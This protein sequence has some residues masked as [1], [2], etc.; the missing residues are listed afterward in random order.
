MAASLSMVNY[1]VSVEQ[2]SNRNAPAQET[3]IAQVVH[4]PLLGL[5]AP[6]APYAPV[7]LFVILF[8]CAFGIQLISKIRQARN[9]IAIFFISLMAAGI[10]SIL[11]YVQNGGGQEVKAGP[12]EVPKA[13]HVSQL[14]SD[15]IKITWNTGA[16]ALGAVRLST[17][18]YVLTKARV[19]TADGGSMAQDHSVIVTHLQP[20]Q[21][22]EFEVFSKNDWYDNN[23]KYI[24]FKM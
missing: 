17:A 2:L 3:E 5:L 23:G 18:P 8:V 24:L 15:S 21:V 10:P 22:Y 1:L 20:G 14:G 9:I 7:A 16:T 6:Y 13:L 12:Q 11:T 19:Y 4:T